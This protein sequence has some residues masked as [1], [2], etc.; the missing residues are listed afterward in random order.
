MPGRTYS[1]SGFSTQKHSSRSFG[2]SLRSNLKQTIWCEQ[3][4]SGYLQFMQYTRLFFGISLFRISRCKSSRGSQN[5]LSLTSSHIRHRFLVISNFLE[6]RWQKPPDT[7]HN[8]P[9]AVDCLLRCCIKSNIILHYV[10]YSTR[11]IAFQVWI[12]FLAA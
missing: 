12:K 8:I 6:K 3:F 1:R 9:T 2:D 5:K 10:Q 11:L 4:E 7:V